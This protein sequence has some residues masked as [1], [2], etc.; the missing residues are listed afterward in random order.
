MIVT[1][2]YMDSTKRTKIMGL[3]TTSLLIL[4]VVLAVSWFALLLYSLAIVAIVWFVLFLMEF[5]DEDI[6]DI[7]SSKMKI[8]QNKFYA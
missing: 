8:K 5:F 4:V 3:T 1:D 6:Y 7:I 2:C